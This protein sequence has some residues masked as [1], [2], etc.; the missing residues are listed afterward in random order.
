MVGEA[1]EASRESEQDDE[2]LGGEEEKARGLICLVLV[3][4]EGFAGSP[5]V[6]DHEMKG[7]VLAPER[8]SPRR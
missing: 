5:M 7:L 1:R 4:A 3:V 8:P 6:N 2:K